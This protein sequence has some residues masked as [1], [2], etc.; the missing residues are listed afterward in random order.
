MG[1]NCCHKEEPEV[2][3]NITIDEFFDP[4][5]EMKSYMTLDPSLIERHGPKNGV[6]LNDIPRTILKQ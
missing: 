2:Y 5:T 3:E 1:N 6:L 4:F